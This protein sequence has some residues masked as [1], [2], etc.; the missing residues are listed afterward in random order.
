LTSICESVIQ[1]RTHV[2]HEDL[3]RKSI[4]SMPVPKIFAVADSPAAIHFGLGRSFST[5]EPYDRCREWAAALH[6]AG[7]GGVAYWPSH[8]PR[9]GDRVSYALF[10]SM[11]ARRWKVGGRADPLDS[12][13]WRGRIGEDLKIQV[14]HPPDD[15]E[16]PFAEDF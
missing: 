14:L 13:L 6:A 5:E 12:A 8:D 9:R 7:F 3:Q 4:R 16:M 1:G 10:D 15:P 11:G 2:L